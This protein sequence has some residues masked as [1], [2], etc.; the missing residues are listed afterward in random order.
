[1]SIH[2]H[3]LPTD[4][5]TALRTGPDAYGLPPEH[6]VSDGDG[7]PCRHCLRMIPSGAAYLTVAHRPFDGLNP[8]TET[9]PIFLCAEPCAPATPRST[10]PEIL[11]SPAYIVRGYDRDERIL[12]GTGKVTAREDIQT[13]A[14]DL[15]RNPDV[16][17]VDIRSAANNCYQCRVTRS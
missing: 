4:T 3:G 8:Y 15:L 16:A 1:M 13:R 17:F 10:L 6:H 5:V 9:G 7:V 11:D 2:F 12:Y 14:R